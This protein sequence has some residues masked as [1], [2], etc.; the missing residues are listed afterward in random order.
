MP[1]ILKELLFAAGAVGLSLLFIVQSFKLTDSAAMMPRLM[2][3]LIIVLSVVMAAQGLA[4]RRRMLLAGQKE[5]IPYVNIPRV[6]TFLVF[7]IAY[8]F[9]M[10]IVG[11]FIATPVFIVGSYLYLRAL[12]L[13]QS[14]LV[15][16]AFCALVYGVFVRIL[17]LPVP[18][19]LLENILE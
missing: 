6:L 1:F 12:N 4:A 8:V 11:Y 14:L 2:A 13:R 17:Y 16:L 5:E 3:G 10:D 18:W 19:G 7:I 15:A 9:S